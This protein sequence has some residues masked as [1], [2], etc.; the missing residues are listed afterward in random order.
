MILGRSFAGEPSTL[1]S[2][3]PAADTIERL[4]LENAIYDETYVS[5]AITKPD[6]FDGS[7]P[8]IWT[9]DTRLHAVFAGDLYGGN[10]SFTESIV[11]SVRIKKRTKKDN[12]FQTIYE[13][14]IKTNEDF[15]IHITDYLEP[16][17]EVEYAYVPVISGGESKY[18]V[19]SVRSSFDKYFICER[20]V[21]YPL[22]MDMDFSRTLNQQVGTVETWGRQRP[23][24]IKNGNLKYYSGDIE[25]T[26]ADISKCMIDWDNAWDYRNTINDFLTNGKPKVFKDFE[27][28]IYMIAV[29]SSPSESH[30]YWNHVTT[31]FSVTECGD[32]YATGDLYD[33]GFIGVD[34]DR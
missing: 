24:I 2:T 32:A 7:I 1:S 28:N 15:E 18:I 27:G 10:V 16:V 14:K 29:T 26:F 30:D 3:L 11:E 31:K 25:C 23:V 6:N 9:F 4:T 19:S 33:N 8:N 12:R 34:V 20:D 17:G 13:K 21:S 5:V 22:M